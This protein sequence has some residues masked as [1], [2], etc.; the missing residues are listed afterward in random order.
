MNEIFVLSISKYSYRMLNIFIFA[1]QGLVR[2][3]V[4]AAPRSGGPRSGRDGVSR[5]PSPVSAG[6]ISGAARPGGVRGRVLVIRHLI[7]VG[8]VI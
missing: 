5:R 7:T 8:L 4:R 2:R 6:C 3:I 1:R